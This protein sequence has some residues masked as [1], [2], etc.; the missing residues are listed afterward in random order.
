MLANPYLAAQ[1]IGPTLMGQ[2]CGDP[3]KLKLMLAELFNKNV[4][5]VMADMILNDKAFGEFAARRGAMGGNTP[6]A[7][8]AYKQGSPASRLNDFTAAMKNFVDAVGEPIE[9]LK[10]AATGPLVHL[11]DSLA[12]MAQQNPEAFKILAEGAVALAAGLAIAGTIA[13]GAAVA[14]LAPTGALV[15]AIIGLGTALATIAVIEW[16]KI[17]SGFDAIKNAIVSFVDWL[18]GVAATLHKY[19]DPFNLFKQSGPE[20]PA[21]ATG[22]PSLQLGSFNPATGAPNVIQS[23]ISLNVDGR[24]LAQAVSDAFETLYNHPTGAPAANGLIA[25]RSPDGNWVST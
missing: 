9:K 20:K 5:A 4:A 15:A 16:D 7:I 21:A 25:A 10:L 18:G 14:A 22:G 1:A 17:R 2:A 24:L 8:E 19:L 11:L 23:N 12:S 6:E 3:A 13:M